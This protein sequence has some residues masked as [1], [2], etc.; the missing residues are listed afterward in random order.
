[1]E[2]IYV[3]PG[4]FCPPTYGHLEIVRKA[5]E[6]FPE[7]V[8]ICSVN[9]GKEKIWFT[10][11]KCKEMWKTY[12]LPGNAKVETFDDF[13]KEK[14]NPSQLVMIRGIRNEKDLEYEKRV[15]LFNHKNFGIS[16]F[17]YIM[18][19]EEFCHISST[20]AKKAAE[21]FDF[22]TL[23]CQ[24]SPMIVSAMLEYVIKIKNLFIVVGKPGSGKSTFLKM[25]SENN[26]NAVCIDTDK[27]VTD[28]LKPLLLR[29]F[30]ERDLAD[31]AMN[32]GEELKAVIGKAWLE[33]LGK[34]LKEVL[35]S[36]NVFLEIPY[37]FQED[38]QSFRYFGGK[39]IYLGCK[40]EAKNRQRVA[41]QR[42]TPQHLPFIKKIPGKEKTIK[43][44]REYKLS[45]TCIDTSGSLEDLRKKTTELNQSIC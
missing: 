11:E 21:E 4:S 38:K 15:V 26:P 10:P 16:K 36:K 6:I 9:P 43:I 28:Q 34:L 42:G 45:L 18:S 23:G 7:V 32:H 27:E 20:A 8:V 24:V 17:L 33:L 13:S 40:N 2:P 3:Y 35:P 5:A 14:V 37:A 12:N 1:M 25:L 30:G 22:L 39:I 44:A 31:I 29:A 19:G 41:I